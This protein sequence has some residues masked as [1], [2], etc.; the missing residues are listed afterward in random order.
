LVETFYRLPIL[1]G[2]PSRHMTLRR[3]CYDVV[4]PS[5]RRNNV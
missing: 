1:K 5:W 3:R 4:L 2:L